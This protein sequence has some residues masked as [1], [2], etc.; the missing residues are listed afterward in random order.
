MV[1]NSKPKIAQV[2]CTYPPYRGGMGQV[3]FEYTKRL[4][5][6]GYNVHVFTTRHNELTQDPEYVHRLP[7]IVQIG[8]AGVM[9]SLYKRLSG[10]DLIHLHYPFFGGAEPVV[11]RKALGKDQG[12]VM[13]YHMDAVADGFKGMIFRAHRR[14]LLPWLIGRVD[15]VLVSSEDYV[16]T[17]DIA[18]LP[19]V[20]DR[21]E[22]HPFGIDLTRFHPGKEPEL[23]SQ[24][25]L[26]P[27]VP[28]LLF[29]GGLDDAHYFK[30]VPILLEA[31]KQLTSE[32]WQVLIVGNGNLRAGF[33]E[34]VRLQKME[35]RIRFVGDVSEEDLA[36][37]YRIA[38][39]HVFPSTHRAEAF[40]LVALE[41]AASGI[42]TIASNLPGVRTVVQDGSTGLLVT[43]QSVSELA[44]A[45]K[46]LIEQKEL[47]ERFGVAARVHAEMHFAW[48]PLITKLEETYRSVLEQQS[49]REY[50][51]PL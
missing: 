44:N 47:R 30:G 7:S 29:V 21:T 14:A 8:N 10:F 1:T 25:G 37:L 2:V 4:R 5:D 19:G 43:P 32:S 40:G 48:D 9:P 3:A 15:R 24:L 51:S 39:I 23:F 46:L 13:T 50:V 26:R 16:K 22:I 33:E 27:G 20:L 17:S 12:L 42:P 6:R 36:R 38:D 34:T 11:V 45:V 18:S 41:A 31:L 49:K 28:I 35:E